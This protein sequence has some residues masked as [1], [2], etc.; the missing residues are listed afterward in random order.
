M[1][2]AKPL[3]KTSSQAM[4]A[5]REKCESVETH[6][7]PLVRDLQARIDRAAKRA[8]MPE[9]THSVP[10]EKDEAPSGDR[11]STPPEPSNPP[12]SL[13]LP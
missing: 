13:P 6:T 10:P 11:E 1:S 7:M 12:P 3:R 2:A 8:G 4:Q 5:Y 9:S